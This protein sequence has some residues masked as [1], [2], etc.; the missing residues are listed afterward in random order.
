MAVWSAVVAT[1]IAV[2]GLMIAS[3]ALLRDVID[4]KIEPK[5][6]PDPVVTASPSAGPP[7]P[8]SPPTQ[9]RDQAQ[10]EVYPTSG[11]PGDAVTV[12]G[13]GFRPGEKVRIEFFEGGKMD[14]FEGPYG[15]GD[16]P[17]DAA[18]RL[19]PTE[20]TILD[21]L[22]C[23]GQEFRIVVTGRTSHDSAEVRFRLR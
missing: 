19:P 10:I 1:V 17:A 18:G 21:E 6:E 15:R 2:L 4:F 20:I 12:S 13:S 8:T 11:Q 16:Y 5:A 23:A 14:Y 3:L 22:C 9:L 7:S